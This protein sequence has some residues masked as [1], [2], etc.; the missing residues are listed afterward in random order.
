M[1]LYY[2]RQLEAK[3]GRQKEEITRLLAENAELKKK[4]AKKEGQEEAWKFAKNIALCEI[5]NGYSSNELKEIFGTMCLDEIFNLTY[6]EATT[7][8]AEWERLKERICIGDILKS[9]HDESV[10]FCVTAIDTKGKIYGISENGNIY[11]ER[12]SNNWKK[13]N[14]HIDVKTMLR[15]IG[16]E[17]E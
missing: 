7:K 17:S 15:Q 8:V 12:D 5:Y 4:S 3:I 16:D 14:K 10:K 6:T 2:E 11:Y 9:K 13:T 1:S